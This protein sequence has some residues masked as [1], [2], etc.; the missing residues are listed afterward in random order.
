MR[1]NN[2]NV[3]YEVIVGIIISINDYNKNKNMVIFFM[4][5]VIVNVIY[6]Y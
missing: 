1:Q 5:E 6:N 4:F 2:G 3:K